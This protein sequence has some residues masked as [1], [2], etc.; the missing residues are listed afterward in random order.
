MTK[1]N[2]QIINLNQMTKTNLQIINL[3]QTTKTNLQIINLNQMTKTNLQMINQIKLVNKISL[4]PPPNYRVVYMT[5]LRKNKI[6]KLLIFL[7][8]YNLMMMTI[9]VS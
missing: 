1:T 8:H 2:L 6:Q 3:N 9:I 4:E 5:K 7:K